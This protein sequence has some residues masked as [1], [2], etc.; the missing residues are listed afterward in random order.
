MVMLP[1]WPSAE[2]PGSRDEIR[3]AVAGLLTT[4]TTTADG[5]GFDLAGPFESRYRLVA[6]GGPV[7]VR[8]RRSSRMEAPDPAPARFG[9]RSSPKTDVPHETPT[10]H[11]PARS[12]MRGRVTHSGPMGSAEPM[13][14]PAREPGTRGRPAE[15]GVHAIRHCST[16]GGGGGSGRDRGCSRRR[17]AR[18]G[19]RPARQPRQPVPGGGQERR[20]LWQPAER[21]SGRRRSKS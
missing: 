2:L 11:N 13:A 14:R 5:P 8:H 16:S 1:R 20:R 7:C 3:G 10:A 9:R 4:C 19:C 17:R 6:P 12:G 21:H 18:R 15:G